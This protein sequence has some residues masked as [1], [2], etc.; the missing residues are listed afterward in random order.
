MRAVLPGDLDAAMAVLLT[1]SDP[2]RP[3]VAAQLLAR[4][5]T[6]DH[7][8][9]RM[10]RAHPI[11]GDGS[12]MAAARSFGEGAHLRSD[13]PLCPKALRIVLEAIEA[14]R[15]DPVRGRPSING[16]SCLLRRIEGI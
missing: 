2:E 9:K 5:H 10:G 3:D 11:F 15:A 7:Y 14:W 13:G 4:A 1:F 12:I 8:R 16:E 6:A